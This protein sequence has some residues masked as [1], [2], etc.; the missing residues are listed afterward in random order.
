MR[1]EGVRFDRNWGSLVIRQGDQ[2]ENS[3]TFTYSSE[4]EIT[5]FYQ[6]FS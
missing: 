6:Y 4:E 5:S 1:G 3:K 2:S